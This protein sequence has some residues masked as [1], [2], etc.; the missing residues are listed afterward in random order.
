MGSSPR[1]AGS[2]RPSRPQPASPASRL[3]S[4]PSG[5][6]RGSG[7]GHAMAVDP[8]PRSPDG[9]PDEFDLLDNGCAWGGV[10]FGSVPLPSRCL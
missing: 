6:R 8:P 1:P 5:R 10:F 3:S 2:G 4:A 9:E 7:H